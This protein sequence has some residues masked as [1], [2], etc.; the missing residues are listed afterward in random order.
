[1]YA[2]VVTYSLRIDAWDEALAALETVQEQIGAFPG[3]RSWV[4]MGNRDTGK[5]AAVAVFESKEALEAVTDQ[6]NEILAGFGRFF[7]SPPSV[8]VG[9]VIVYIDNS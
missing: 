5:G 7:S 9:E 2:R 1:M 6:V 8:D 4:N 3:L